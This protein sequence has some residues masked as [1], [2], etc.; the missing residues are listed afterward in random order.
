[1]WKRKLKYKEI[2]SSD[3][4]AEITR[5][6]SNYDP[7]DVY[8][9]LSNQFYALYNDL[10]IQGAPKAAAMVFERAETLESYIS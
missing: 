4:I 1:M 6:L 9:A 3:S 10:L 2:K 8:K 5:V 7:D